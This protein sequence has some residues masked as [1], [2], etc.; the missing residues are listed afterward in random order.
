MQR[1]FDVKTQENS[2]I[3]DMFAGLAKVIVV[4]VKNF[5]N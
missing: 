2:S 5:K 1:L 3:K 4:K